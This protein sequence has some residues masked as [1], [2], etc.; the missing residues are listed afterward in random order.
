MAS[1]RPAAAGELAMTKM[2]LPAEVGRQL[3][4]A[5][6]C[7]EL[8]DEGGRTIGFF[9]PALSEALLDPQISEEEL[10]RREREDRTYTSE[11][12]RARLRGL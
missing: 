1:V 6:Q 4:A 8:C 12:V 10:D 3:T 2:T 11:E 9:T 7:V 5:H